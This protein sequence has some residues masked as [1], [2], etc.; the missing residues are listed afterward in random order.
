M[1]VIA[2]PDMRFQT[3]DIFQVHK[4]TFSRVAVLV[5]SLEELNLADIFANPGAL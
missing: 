3:T 1:Q 2:I 4:D 5:N